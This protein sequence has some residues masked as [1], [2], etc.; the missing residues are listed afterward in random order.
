MAEYDM[1]SVTGIARVD[2]DRAVVGAVWLGAQYAIWPP[3]KYLDYCKMLYAAKD[4]W[5]LYV[6]QK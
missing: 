2:S 6:I 4:S 1:V 3:I 5:T